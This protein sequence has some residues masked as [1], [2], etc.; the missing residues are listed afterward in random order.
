MIQPILPV[1]LKVI[2]HRLRDLHYEAL[3]AVNRAM[4]RESPYG[5]F[6]FGPSADYAKGHRSYVPDTPLLHLKAAE[7]ASSVNIFVGY[8]QNEGRHL[9]PSFMRTDQGFRAHLAEI[10]PTL[11]SSEIAYMSKSLYQI[12]DYESMDQGQ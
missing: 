9:T 11:A 6:T 2:V 7:M 3:Y 10:F 1:Q 4:V 8:R 12:L 5:I